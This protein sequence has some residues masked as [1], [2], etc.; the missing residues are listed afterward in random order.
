MMTQDNEMCKSKGQNVDKLI[1][2]AIRLKY[3]RFA[4]GNA[5]GNT[6]NLPR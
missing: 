1:F 5:K 2:V 3:E 4:V 6:K